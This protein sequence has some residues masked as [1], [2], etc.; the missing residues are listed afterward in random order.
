M[1]DKT[2]IAAYAAQ[3]IER[4]NERLRALVQ[5]SEP[6]SKEVSEA[7][8]QEINLT[9]QRLQAAISHLPQES[10]EEEEEDQLD[11]EVMQ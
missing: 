8:I 10:E 9:M 3:E 6:A 5:S 7:L 11:Y 1:D 4:I 2:I